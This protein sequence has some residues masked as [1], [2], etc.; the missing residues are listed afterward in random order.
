M[1]HHQPAS[2][3]DAHRRRKQRCACS[4]VGE[5]VTDPWLLARLATTDGPF[6]AIARFGFSFPV[7]KTQPDPYELGRE[8]KWHEHIQDGTGTLVPIVGFGLAYTFAPVTIGLGGTGFFNAYENSDGDR[9]PPRFYL[10]HR[11]SV[12]LLDHVLTPF[13]EA[14]LAHEG[15]EY[16]HGQIG[17]EG[18]NIRTEI[19][20]GGGLGWRLSDVWSMEG[21][22]SGRMA[23][24]TDA[25]TFKSAGTFSLSITAAFDPWDT[26]EEKEQKAEAAKEA[27]PHI[28][29]RRHDGIVEFEKK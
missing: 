29:E 7:G 23:S 14:T 19:Y 9:A 16:W 4:S 6:V 28:V 2:N 8:G 5:G 24:L 3:L 22:A 1:P 12:G 26:A 17:G 20:L 15:E 10:N 27:A 21:S 25:P 11:V 13:V 18:S